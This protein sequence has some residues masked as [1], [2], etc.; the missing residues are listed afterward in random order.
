[1]LEG[2]SF[3]HQR[4]SPR[5][6]RGVPTGRRKE[7]IESNIDQTPLILTL[8]IIGIAYLAKGRLHPIV[9]GWARD[10]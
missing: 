4:L 10:E 3:H 5:V 7:D 1:M 2:C 9:L 8:K 6:E